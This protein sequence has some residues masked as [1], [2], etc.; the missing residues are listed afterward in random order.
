MTKAE[1]SLHLDYAAL[2]S[3]G[4]IMQKDDDFF[5]IR[6]N[7]PGG[8]VAADKLSRIQ[9]VANEYGRSEIRL[10]AR[11]GIEI[12][13]IE[14]R[15]IDAARRA[16]SEAGLSLGACGPRFRAV[17]ACPGSQVC[18]L[19]LVNSQGFS[20]RI[21]K[22][23][24]GRLLPH[25]FKISVSGCPNSCSKP[26]ENEIGFMGIVEPEL[27]SQACNGCGLCVD[28]CKESAIS[29]QDGRPRRSSERCLLCGNCIQSCPTEAWKARRTGYVVFA[30]G[31]MGRHPVLGER[32]A[33]FVDEDRGIKIID[34]CLDLY[35]REGRRRERF[36]DL[37]HRIG[38]EKLKAEVLSGSSEDRT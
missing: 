16:L 36:G 25:K 29:L 30:G 27:D 26:S 5:S 24:K 7:F 14:F 8:K 1:L 9:E 10:T 4:I 2:K 21:D 22:G 3:G 17:T 11:Q 15:K 19:G 35:N 31:R 34:L 18:K 38:L 6:L 32:I 23:F 12:P 37:I 13:W 28:T 20:A 33:D